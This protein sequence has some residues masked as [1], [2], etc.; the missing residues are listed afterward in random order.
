MGIFS[1]LSGNGDDDALHSEE[2]RGSG[3]GKELRRL[4]EATLVRGQRLSSSDASKTLR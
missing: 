4:S 2:I 3:V 1:D